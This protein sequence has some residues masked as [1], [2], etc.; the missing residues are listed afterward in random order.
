VGAV[1]DTLLPL[2][3]V[4]ALSPVPVL[5]VVLLLQ[6]DGAAHTSAAFL[7]GWVGGVAGATLV[8]SLLLESAEAATGTGAVAAWGAIV[9]G[10]LLV[11][12]AVRQWRSRPRPG[13]VPG[14]PRWALAVDRFTVRRAGG[15]GLLLSAVS[16]KNLPVCVAA[17]GTIAAGGLSRAQGAWSLIGFTVLATSTVAVPVA[18]HAVLGARTTRPLDSLR[19]WLT[20]HG[21]AIATTVLLALAVLLIGQGVRGL[22]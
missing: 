5:T 1:V 21:A 6:S 16:P 13:E 8:A 4:L 10:G 14:L 19:R 22:P 11:A 17:G 3:L 9:L 7:V 12:L 2:S 18:A 20:E 15:L